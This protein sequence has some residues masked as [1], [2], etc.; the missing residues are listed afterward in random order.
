[1]VS[2]GGSVRALDGLPSHDPYAARFTV[3]ALLHNNVEI[4]RGE[5]DAHTRA[6]ETLNDGD[7]PTTL[8][9]WRLDVKVG[10]IVEL[11]VRNDGP[12]AVLYASIFGVA[13]GR[14]HV[15]PSS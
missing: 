9:R 14:E 3:V 4:W 2:R 12:D 15:R 1:M 10:D 5:Y 13:D 8:D 7:L 11:E 6:D